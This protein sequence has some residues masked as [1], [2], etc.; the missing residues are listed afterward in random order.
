MAALPAASLFALRG[1][2]CNRPGGQA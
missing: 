2:P 1:A